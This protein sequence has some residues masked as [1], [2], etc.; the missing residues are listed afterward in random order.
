MCNSERFRNYTAVSL[1]SGIGGIDIGL[2]AAGFDIVAQ[3]EIDRF[4]NDILE[5]HAPGWWPNAVRFADVR[6]FGRSNIGNQRI[7]IIAGGFPCQPFSAAG[8]RL[9]E[10]DDRN[11]W[12]A[13]RRIIGEIRPKAILLENVK[14]LITQNG[15]EPGYM[16]IVINEL[17]QMGYVCGY[18]VIS[19]ASAGAPHQRDRVWIVGYTDQIGRGGDGHNRGKRQDQTNQRETPENQPKRHRRLNG[20]SAS[21]TD[22]KMAD[23]HKIR[24]QRPR[25]RSFKTIQTKSRARAFYRPERLGGMGRRRKHKRETKPRLARHLNGIPNWLDRPKWPAGFGALQ[26][27]WEPSRVVENNHNDRVARVEALGNAVIPQIPYYIARE[28]IAILQEADRLERP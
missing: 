13:T 25:F 22:E 28:I 12:P 27:E 4:C 21:S 26:H 3:V 20:F 23:A 14:G 24:L 11:M 7:D 19:A 16:G 1:F 2:S 6:D 9:A 15:G 8:R 18:G 17:S 10:N 5:K